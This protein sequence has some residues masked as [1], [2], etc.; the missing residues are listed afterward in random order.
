[1]GVENLR[2]ERMGAMVKSYF[3]DNKEDLLNFILETCISADKNTTVTDYNTAIRLL[4]DFK[5]GFEVADLPDETKTEYFKIINSGIE[6]CNNGR[7][8]LLKRN[9]LSD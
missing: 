7:G 9:Q 6:I 2:N 5:I 3:D 8:E 1:M 4:E